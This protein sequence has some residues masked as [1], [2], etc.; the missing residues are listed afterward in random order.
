MRVPS[1][2][3]SESDAENVLV[4]TY[5][6]AFGEY[7]STHAEAALYRASLLSRDFVERGLGPEEIVALH[8]QAFA[9]ACEGRGDRERLRLSTDSLEF[10]LEVMI[11]Y[12]VQHTEYLE[13]SHQVRAVQLVI[14]AMHQPPPPLRGGQSATL[15]GGPPSSTTSRL[16]SQFLVQSSIAKEA[17]VMILTHNNSQRL[18]APSRSGANSATTSSNTSGPQWRNSSD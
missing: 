7:S 15:R 18:C 3:G 11:A 2:P 9:L 12:G 17:A 14:R 4:Q 10:L 1:V 6:N 8:G 16:I 13:L 5:A